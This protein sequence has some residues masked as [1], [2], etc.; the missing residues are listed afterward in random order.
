MSTANF[1]VRLLS[2]HKSYLHHFTNRKIQALGSFIGGW[3]GFAYLLEYHSTVEANN[4]I[5]AWNAV[6]NNAEKN[7]KKIGETQTHS[8]CWFSFG[9][10]SEDEDRVDIKDKVKVKDEDEDNYDIFDVVKKM[11]EISTESK[12]E[13]KRTLEKYPNPFS[14]VISQQAPFSFNLLTT[15]ISGGVCGYLFATY[16]PFCLSALI[17]HN[18]LN[19]SQTVNTK[20][21]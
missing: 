9:N 17:I 20:T 8:G 13:Y 3:C 14:I 6:A 1:S 15:V 18:S 10:V 12:T 2:A 11:R 16:Y 5:D 7:K 4:A 21:K 19:Y